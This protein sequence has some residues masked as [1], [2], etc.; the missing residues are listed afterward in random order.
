MVRA[1][2]PEM[3][4]KSIAVHLDPDAVTGVT[5]WAQG[6]CPAQ[7]CPERLFHEGEERVH[8]CPHA[9]VASSDVCG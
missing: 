2:S 1:R 8:R 4:E 6:N 9:F 5:L 3:V 7:R